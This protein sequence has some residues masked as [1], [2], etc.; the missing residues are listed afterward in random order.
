[1]NTYSM[2]RLWAKSKCKLTILTTTIRPGSAAGKI[3]ITPSRTKNPL[4]GDQEY[5]G[6]Q[7][8]PSPH[9]LPQEASHA[10][11]ATAMTTQTEQTKKHDGNQNKI[12]GEQDN[13][14][15]FVMFH[16]GQAAAWDRKL[17]WPWRVELWTV[18]QNRSKEIWVRFHPQ[19]SWYGTTFVSGSHS[20]AEAKRKTYLVQ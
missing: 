9:L 12:S 18:E 16:V 5:H 15:N 19:D 1:M 11:H 3:K 2:K 4:L 8:L 20:S 10:K 14:G 6:Y 7:G 13:K 17:V